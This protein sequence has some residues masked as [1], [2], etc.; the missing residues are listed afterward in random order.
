MLNFNSGKWWHRQAV[1]NTSVLYWQ[2]K[3]LINS[4]EFSIR[5]TE[6]CTDVIMWYQRTDHSHIGVYN[7]SLEMPCLDQQDRQ[8]TYQHKREE[9]RRNH[10]GRGQSKHITYS[11]CVCSFKLLIMQCACAILPSVACPAVQTFSE[12]SQKRHDFRK[13]V[14]KIKYLLIFSTSLV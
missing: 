11:E 6:M 2:G 14:L 5:D 12:L 4:C 10:C 1:N 9:R 3:C 8:C 13:K 7:R